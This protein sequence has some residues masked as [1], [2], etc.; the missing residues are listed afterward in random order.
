MPFHYGIARD[1]AGNAISGS[2]IYVYEAVTTGGARASLATLYST[3]KQT[4]ETGNPV[5]ADSDGVFSFWVPAGMY[6]I[7][8]VSKFGDTLSD[9]NPIP[10]GIAAEAFS[11]DDDPGGFA[12]SSGAL[13]LSHN[14]TPEAAITAP[15]GSLCLVTGAAGTLY[16]KTSGTGNTGWTLKVS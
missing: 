1:A 3:Q 2:S 4:T 12:F 10:I 16:V 13:V 7:K 5:T 8:V 11:S 14:A 6:R 9:D 15:P